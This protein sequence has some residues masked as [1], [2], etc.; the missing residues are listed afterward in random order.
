[1]EKFRKVEFWAATGLYL[2]VVFAVL[3]PFLLSGE[4]SGTYWIARVFEENN[5]HFDVFVHVLMP[6]LMIATVGYA[7]F[8]LINNW[9]TPFFLEKKRF[10]GGVPLA[11]LAFVL[12]WVFTMVAFTYRYGYMLGYKDMNVFHAIM[13][14]RGFGAMLVC[15]ITYAF[16]YA[17]KYLYFNYLHGWFQQQNIWRKIT[18]EMVLFFMVWVV[19]LVMTAQ[20]PH[21]G[22]FILILFIGFFLQL[23]Y[24]TAYFFIFPPFLR[25]EHRWGILGRNLLITIMLSCGLAMFMVGISFNARALEVLLFLMVLGEVMFV[26]PIAWWLAKLRSKQ[27][28]EVLVL[29]K[30]LGRSSANLDFLRS[31]INPHF[32]FNA[33]N[34]LYGT[35]L[36]ENASRTSEGV[37]KLGDM[38]RFMLHENHQEK[39]ELSKEVGYLQNY[40]ALQRLRIQ[41][42]DDIKIE[43]NIS[44]DDCDHP[45][46]PML[47]IPF[48]ENA[49]KHGISLRN[50][51]WIVVSLSCDATHIYFDAYNSVHL[52]PEN[53]PEKTSLGIG[54]NNVKNR[55]ALL[56]PRRHELSI[57]QTATEFFVH[58]TIAINK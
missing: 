58:L 15:A 25:G 13:A 14:R 20:Y 10:Y 12:L 36:Q 42:S 37:Q 45:I 39:I 44:E 19:S 27:K 48:V 4:E 34:T 18:V 54:L 6:K 3:F 23:T 22:T 28:D 31:Q 24:I 33:L 21:G 52:K 7:T 11:V 35:A 40:I 56:Y 55:L 46:A 9:I 47:L 16:Y 50:R 51:S 29:E 1:M 26:F 8:L 17:V 41:Q 49:F 32:L 5:M 53:D 43:V 2:L 38:M 57:R 30:A